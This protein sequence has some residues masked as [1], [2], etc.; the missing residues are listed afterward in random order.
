MKSKILNILAIFAHSD[1]LSIFC[2]RILAK[3]V[4]Q[5]LNIIALCCTSGN[6]GTLSTDLTKEQVAKMRET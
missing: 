5:G 6:V 1:D 2:A 3:W 4:K